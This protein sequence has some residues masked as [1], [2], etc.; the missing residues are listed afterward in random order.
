LASSFAAPPSVPKDSL[1]ETLPLDA[2]PLGLGARSIPANNPLTPARVALGR[3]LFF[4]PILSRDNTIACATC[5]QPEHGF[6]SADARAR[7]I[8]GRTGERRAPTLLNRAYGAAFFWDGRTS[9]LEEQALE[10][11]ENPLEMGSSVP[12][13]LA[14]LKADAD[15]ARRFAA[16]FDDG[17]TASNLARALASFERV[18]VRGDSPVDR[19]RVR[20]DHDALNAAERHGLWLYESKGQC[21]KCHGGANFT[22]ESF[23]NTGV[24][25]GGADLGRHRATKKDEDRGRFK[26]PTLRGVSLRPPYMHDGSIPTL[27]AVVDF[28]NRGGVHNPHLDPA[29]KP[30]NLSDDERRA[31]AAFLK[32]L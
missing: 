2:T 11:I 32:V 17:V 23:H 7:G 12:D 27:E 31:L 3:K 16:A 30:L 6:A 1:P 26:T 9:T 24:G 8:G 20:S 5:H 13:A 10:P 15:Y 18:L 4:D 19:F 29:L 21:W 25:W 14:R 28:Y 22:D